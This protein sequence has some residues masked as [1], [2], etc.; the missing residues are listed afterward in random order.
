MLSEKLKEAQFTLDDRNYLPHVTLIR[1]ANCQQV[2]PKF[3][4]FQWEVN[5]FVLVESVR[6]DKGAKYEVID[7]WP[8]SG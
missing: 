6:S 8:L 1:N 4:A 2:M 7:R 5:E 3:D